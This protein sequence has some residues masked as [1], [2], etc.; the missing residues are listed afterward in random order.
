MIGKKL[1]LLKNGK[2]EYT[3]RV[4]FDIPNLDEI[5]NVAT[6]N[7]KRYGYVILVETI[8]FYVRTSLLVKYIYFKTKKKIKEIYHKYFPHKVKENKEKEVSKFLRMVSDYKHKIKNI[9]DK[10]EEEENNY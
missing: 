6:K 7:S 1:I 3:E 10:I 4:L 8:R 2:I 5:K 9:K